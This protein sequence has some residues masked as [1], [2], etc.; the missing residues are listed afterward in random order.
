MVMI[1]YIFKMMKNR[2]AEG[3]YVT[4]IIQLVLMTVTTE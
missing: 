2:Q 3:K 4:K 1:K